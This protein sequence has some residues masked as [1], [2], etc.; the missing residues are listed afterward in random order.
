MDVIAEARRRLSERPELK[1]TEKRDHIEVAAPRKG[2][3]TVALAV[4]PN[5]FDVY[6]AGWHEHFDS[7]REALNCFMYGLLGDCRLRVHYRGNT[8]HRWTLEQRRDGQWLR[9]GTTGLILYPFW[10]RRREVVLSNRT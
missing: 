5:G 10:R 4:E 7:A 9:E 8:A 6:F 2:G 1:V 3:F